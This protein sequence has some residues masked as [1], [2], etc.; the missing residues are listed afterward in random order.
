M[1]IQKTSANIFSLHTLP[2]ESIRATHLRKGE[3][4][5]KENLYVYLQERIPILQNYFKQLPQS[6][7][8]G[9][10]MHRILDRYLSKQGFTYGA[11]LPFRL[12]LKPSHITRENSGP[13]F[14]SER[15]L[16]FYFENGFIG[17]KTIKSVSQERLKALHSRFTG[18]LQGSTPD[19]SRL[20]ILRQEWRD[21]DVFD[22]VTNP[23]IVSKVSSLLGP[24]I[25]MRFTSMHEVP[26]GEGSFACMTNQQISDFYAHSDMNL[27]T[28]A[29]PRV[30]TQDP[31]CDKDAISV[32]I[33]ISGTT[34]HN[35][36]L[37]VFPGTHKWDITTPLTYLNQFK[38]DPNALLET[39]K[40]LATKGF[41]NQLNANHYLFYKYLLASSEQ[42]RLCETSRTEMYMQP[43]DCL[44]FTT[45]L[46]HGSKINTTAIS[47]LGMSIRYSRATN[48]ENN[49]N[50]TIVRSLFTDEEQLEMGLE[51]GDERTPIFQVLGNA[52]HE[53]S[54]PVNLAALRNILRNKEF[55]S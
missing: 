42:S 1:S 12:D 18:M 33:S 16:D 37:F 32:W 47:R 49:E 40:L 24:N 23:E 43:G 8:E 46:L 2:K 50:L 41:A 7:E 38:D 45:H 5:E 55:R 31:F 30:D 53:K 39:G 17:P 10:L 29:I 3:W 52:H 25:K 13:S 19:Q 22:L 9:V 6:P 21:P 54:K 36:P 26:P 11:S 4:G 48:E 20:K 28:A 44:F 35:A 27:G 34:E 14:F 15:E 51:K